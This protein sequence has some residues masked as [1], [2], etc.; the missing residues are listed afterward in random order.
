MSNSFNNHIEANIT[1][2]VPFHSLMFKVP[3]HILPKIYST[4]VIAN[5]LLSF[6]IFIVLFPPRKAKVLLRLLNL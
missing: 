6:S 5:N 4:I 1:L 3:A 2:P